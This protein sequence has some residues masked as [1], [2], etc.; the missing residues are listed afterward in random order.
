MLSRWGNFLIA[1]GRREILDNDPKAVLYWLEEDKLIEALELPS[2]GDCSYPGFLEID[3]GHA[4]VSYYSS[5][6]GNGEPPFPAA[7]YVADIA[8]S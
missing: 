5:H 2:G 8:V 4:L 3:P 1:G 7:I 6:E